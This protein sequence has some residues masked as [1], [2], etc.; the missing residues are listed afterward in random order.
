M[1][2]ILGVLLI[3]FGFALNSH[4]LHAQADF[5]ATNRKGCAPLTVQFSDLSSGTIDVVGKNWT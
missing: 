4:G 3:W 5:G 1:V 2:R